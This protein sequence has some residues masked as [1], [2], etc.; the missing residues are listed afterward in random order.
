MIYLV[1]FFN[2]PMMAAGGLLISATAALAGPTYTFALNSS[3]VLAAEHQYQTTAASPRN[4]A[5]DRR[6]SG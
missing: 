3:D 4:G 1:S 5:N 2:V 6:H